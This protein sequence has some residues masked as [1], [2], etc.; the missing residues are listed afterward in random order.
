M[1]LD[2]HSLEG[3]QTYTRAAI[4]YATIHAINELITEVL[5]LQVSHFSSDSVTA[6]LQNMERGP[7]VPQDSSEFKLLTELKSLYDILRPLLDLKAPLA[8]RLKQW[9]SVTGEGTTAGVPTGKWLTQQFRYGTYWST[10]Q[11][12]RRNGTRIL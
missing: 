6:F 2:P 8:A 7:Q 9:P 12:L 1:L 5:Q 3:T 4:Y 11:A 10:Q